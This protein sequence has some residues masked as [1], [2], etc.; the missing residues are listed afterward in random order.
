MI[1]DV[2]KN[3]GV[4]RFFDEVFE[5]KHQNFG[6][7]FSPEERDEVFSRRGLNEV[8]ATATFRP[9]D[10]MMV[11][12]DVKVSPEDYA[13]PWGLV[14][15]NKA[16]ALMDEGATLVLNQAHTR[17]FGLAKLCRNVNATLGCD[18]QVNVYV[19]PPNAQGFPCHWDNHDV[20]V[21]QIE[22]KKEWEF[23][24][25]GP[26]LPDSSYKFDPHL[27]K[28][29]DLIERTVLS[30]GDVCF[31]PRG[32]MHRVKTFDDT[33]SIHLTLGLF[34]PSVG[35]VLK[36]HIDR[37][38]ERYPAMRRAVRS[39]D[40]VAEIQ[41]MMAV[42]AKSDLPGSIWSLLRQRKARSGEFREAPFN[43]NEATRNL[44]MSSRVR[45][46]PL[47]RCQVLEQDGIPQLDHQGGCEEIE[48][49]SA[50]DLSDLL[51][52]DYQTVDAWSQR[53]S[54]DDVLDFLS[55]MAKRGVLEIENRP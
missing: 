6:S 27:H 53:Y 23:Y 36:Y 7:A 30:E 50:S 47:S 15:V 44:S 35:D 52:G 22:G 10:L 55:G 29:G 4:D 16:L 11:S 25:G 1:S 21:V 45:R 3:F 49:I 24:E 5:N 37:Q 19:S 43:Q 31:V 9:Q 32:V 13:N 39:A 18:S 20:F 26:K 41:E 48:G 17:V 40:H 2:L 42:L 8:L 38:F 34:W 28:P 33:G 46:N 54:G 12:Q 51:S 14:D